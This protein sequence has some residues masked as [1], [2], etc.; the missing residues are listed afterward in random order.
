MSND[1][2]F[3][4]SHC[5]ESNG[6][7]PSSIGPPIEGARGPGPKNP[8]FWNLWNDIPFE[9]SHQDGSSATN[10]NSIGYMVKEGYKVLPITIS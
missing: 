8:N 4:P 9:P 1:I 10:F 3:E 7:G 6:A 5:A 2:L